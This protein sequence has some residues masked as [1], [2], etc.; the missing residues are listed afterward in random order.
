M[1]HDNKVSE[2][3]E[4][5]EISD[6]IKEMKLQ[7]LLWLLK[8]N[9]NALKLHEEL[10]NDPVHTGS[11]IYFIKNPEVLEKYK[12]YLRKKKNSLT[13]AKGNLIKLKRRAEFR[14][15]SSDQSEGKDIDRTETQDDKDTISEKS[16]KSAETTQNITDS[17]Q[18]KQS[19]NT[20]DVIE[21]K[22]K[23]DFEVNKEES[24]IDRTKEETT[25]KHNIRAQ[26]EDPYNI[27]KR[28]K[29]L[30]SD[31]NDKSDVDR[32]QKDRNDKRYTSKKDRY[33]SFDDRKEKRFDDFR[34][35]SYVPYKPKR[36]MNYRKPKNEGKKDYFMYGRTSIPFI[37]KKAVII[38]SQ[39]RRYNINEEAKKLYGEDLHTVLQRFRRT[40][41]YLKILD[42]KKN[43]PR[44]R[45][46]K[47]DLINLDNYSKLHSA[48]TLEETKHVH[49][50]T[51]EYFGRGLHEFIASFNTD[52]RLPISTQ[53]P[54]GGEQP[55]STTTEHDHVVQNLIPIL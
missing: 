17:V 13:S 38:T 9:F 6:E 1:E 3:D 36:N 14:T 43:L 42:I 31:T 46:K 41:E 4:S 37:G 19:L 27:V 28:E 18:D 16:E 53:Q 32:K 45:S 47:K 51:Y 20:E 40:P 50:L 30:W 23:E 34:Q 33:K 22:V 15:G 39:C 29:I 48:L 2:T 25:E 5:Q 54:N 7:Q 10:M 12:D 49:D 24:N 8:K 52:D 44:L 26:E 55:L 11:R 21:K 35:D